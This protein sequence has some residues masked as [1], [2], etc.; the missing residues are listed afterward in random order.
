M[1][2]QFPIGKSPDDA[3]RQVSADGAWEWDGQDWVPTQPPPSASGTQVPP[4]P[5]GAIGGVRTLWVV[6]GLLLFFPIGFVL[7]FFS[8]WT[9]KTK[10][11]VSG[12]TAGLV[13]LAIVSSALATPTV[14]P[15]T[16]AHRTQTSGQVAAADSAAGAKAAA[17]KIAADK[18]AADKAAA[19]KAAADKAAADKAAADKA[20]AANA[21]A[22]QAAAT[23]AAAAAAAQPP[24]A[25]TDPY[26]AATAAG[27]TAVC[28]DGT[29]SYSAHRS[30]TCSGHGG[31]H[32]WT[33]KVGAAGPGAH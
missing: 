6:L 13:L 2:K 24:A 33:G 19:D 11:V 26:P 18:A 21:A 22:A 32:W 15:T 14:N 23:Q 16:V 5:P 10:L 8:R 30:G 4:M 17:D 20:A 9:K 27:A 7:I 29:Y 1:P 3:N 31:V 25:A 12:A 28:A